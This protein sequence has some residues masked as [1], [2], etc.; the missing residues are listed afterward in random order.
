MNKK[1]I[2][3]FKLKIANERTEVKAKNEKKLAELEAKNNEMEKTLSDYK[4]EGENKW[5]EFKIEFN[6][7]LDEIG[8]AF[9]NLSNKK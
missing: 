2:A 7:D 4:E 3:D 6:R 5:I 1:T 9:S 8:K